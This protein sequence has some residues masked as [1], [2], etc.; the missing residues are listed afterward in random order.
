MFGSR[1]LFVYFDFDA[2]VVGGA[3]VVVGDVLL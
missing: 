2:A 1:G 3:G